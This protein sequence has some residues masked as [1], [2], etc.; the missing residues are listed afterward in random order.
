MNLET[1]TN[2]EEAK[3]TYHNLRGYFGYVPQAIATPIQSKDLTFVD[4]YAQIMTGEVKIPDEFWAQTCYRYNY[5][6]ENGDTVFA[7]D[8]INAAIYI[9]RGIFL[10]M[11]ED[12]IWYIV[13]SDNERQRIKNIDRLIAT[14]EAEQFVRSIISELNVK[15]LMEANGMKY[16][17]R[18]RDES[19]WMIKDICGMEFNAKRMILKTVDEISKYDAGRRIVKY[20]YEYDELMQATQIT[21][22]TPKQK[23]LV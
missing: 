17:P 23:T 10:Q 12:S 16:K 20:I 5:M 19:E 21:E 18:K 3:V 22:E 11:D 6:D 15:Y 8:F 1:K 9:G 4:G 13:S 2:Q 14:S 7:D